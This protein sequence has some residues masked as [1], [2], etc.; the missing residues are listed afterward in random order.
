MLPGKTHHLRSR[1]FA[2]LALL[3]LMACGTASVYLTVTRPAEI[4]LKGFSKIAIG[5]FVD[6]EG[7]AGA[8]AVD[9]ADGITA[10][11]FTSGAY[12]ILDRDNLAALLSEH[13]LGEAGLIDES[14]AA[15]IGQFI[16]SAA[17]VF[18]RIQ[19]DNYK[20]ELT[21]EKPYTD[22]D[23]KSHQI[24]VRRGTY[25]LA[26]NM[27]VIDVQ[28]ARILAVKNIS[29]TKRATKRADKKDP[30]SIDIDP[31]LA[32]CIA[33]IT[34]QFIRMIAPYEEQVRAAFL[35]DKQLPE[36][37]RAV[38]LFRVG[39]WADGIAILAQATKR[40]GLPSD[41]QAKTFY[42]LGLAKIYV[43]EFDDAVEQLKTALSLDPTSRR[44]QQTILKAKDEKA[45]AEKLKE[46]M[47]GG[48][49]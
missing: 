41:I 47:K 48:E 11:L 44:I 10:A 18:G 24:H 6:E 49:A 22:K 38:G 17:L 33:D 36:T 8:H 3:L 25:R 5:D 39:E 13:A 16:G 40:T 30:A 31:L 1:R 45:K 32:S 42:N 7:Q 34:R 20:E 26:V 19:T 9:I 12:E 29:A 4:N 14:T 43:G 37:D 46:Q 23:G 2:A 27:K 35:T 15:Q 21:K 28:T